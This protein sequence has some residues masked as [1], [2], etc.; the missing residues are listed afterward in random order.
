[1]FSHFRVLVPPSGVW[2]NCWWHF[3]TQPVREPLGSPMP[4]TGASGLRRAPVPLGEAHAWTL[5]PTWTGRMRVDRE[6]TDS[7]LESE[8]PWFLL[9]AGGPQA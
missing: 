6:Q 3:L 4:G 1:M 2:S 7:A 9:L 8:L 5:A